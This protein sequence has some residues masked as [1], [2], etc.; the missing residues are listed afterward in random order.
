MGSHELEAAKVVRY[1]EGVE[2]IE[3]HAATYPQHLIPRDLVETPIG[4]AVHACGPNRLGLFVVDC[5]DCVA[6]APLSD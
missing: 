4:R 3:R 2:E 5:A 6:G 1:T